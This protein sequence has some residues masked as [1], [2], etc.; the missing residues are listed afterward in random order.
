MNVLEIHIANPQCFEDS[1]DAQ[2]FQFVVSLC[3]V[4][5]QGLS[6]WIYNNSANAS[7]DQDRS[8]WGS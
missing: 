5:S 7:G 4:Q 8:S 6:M 1:F 2:I 3:C